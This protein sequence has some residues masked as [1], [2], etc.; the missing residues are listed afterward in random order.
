MR[1]GAVCLEV[2]ETMRRDIKDM[3]KLTK[4]WV[5][6]AE[7]VLLEPHSSTRDA[8]EQIADEMR[9]REAARKFRIE[10]TAKTPSRY[11]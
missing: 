5:S 8:A 2:S 6:K 9:D 10:Q 3:T 11:E 4:Q 7:R 1:H